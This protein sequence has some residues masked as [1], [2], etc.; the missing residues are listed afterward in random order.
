M[1]RISDNEIKRIELTL[2]NE[3]NSFCEKHNL[4]YY[5]AYGTLLGAVRH[6]GF[7]PWDNDIDVCMP[8]PDY[9]KLIELFKKNPNS[10][11]SKI[12]LKTPF[13]KDYQYSYCKLIDKT[14]I[15]HEVTMKDKYST[16]IWIDIFPID[17]LPNDK[18]KLKKFVLKMSKSRKYYSY[19]IEKKFSGKSLIGKL[20][21]N[22]VKI[23]YTPIYFILNQKVRFDRKCQIYNYTDANNFSVLFDWFPLE[24]LFDK[25]LLEIDYYS[26]EDNKYPGFKNYDK[27]LTNLYGDYM[28]LPPKEEQ[29]SHEIEAYYV[30]EQND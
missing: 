6:N 14:T 9:N 29:V 28:K 23:I 7:I 3:F 15:V 20:K 27:Y 2:L 10:I 16:S 25:N 18:N 22:I 30:E 19:T 21:F 17:A 24:S 26:F 1:E 5:L 13:S 4:T 8:R 12:E 11:S